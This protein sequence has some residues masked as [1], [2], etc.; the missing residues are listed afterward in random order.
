MR[1]VAFSR[2]SKLVDDVGAVTRHELGVAKLL[3]AVHAPTAVSVRRSA[4]RVALGKEVRASGCP[5]CGA[6]NVQSTVR[7]TVVR[8]RDA[9]GSGSKGVKAKFRL[10]LCCSICA[11]TSSTPV[12]RQGRYP[13]K[14]PGAEQSAGAGVKRP[15]TPSPPARQTPSSVGTL[16]G[17]GAALSGGGSVPRSSPLLHS[18]LPSLTAGRSGARDSLP[19]ASA[20]KRPRKF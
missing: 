7:S 11:R 1:P 5:Q 13:K 16:A 10:R 9:S 8:S 3:L 6:P 18:P 12:P 19:S 14:R 17:I 4:A 15:R 20:E 2:P